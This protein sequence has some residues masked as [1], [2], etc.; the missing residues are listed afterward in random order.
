MQTLSS[1][2]TR[3]WGSCQLEALMLAKGPHTRESQG[4]PV[5]LCSPRVTNL[6]ELTL[7]FHTH[8]A[9]S[10]LAPCSHVQNCQA[11]TTQSVC[12]NVVNMGVPNLN[13]LVIL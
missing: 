10:F 12:G 11:W 5:Q 9:V 6:S 7:C 13:P 1:V 3:R 4:P 2:T 8:R